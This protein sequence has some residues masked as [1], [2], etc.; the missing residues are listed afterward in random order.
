M[1]RW[2]KALLL[3]AAVLWALVV[4]RPYLF[5]TDE[6]SRGFIGDDLS[7]LVLG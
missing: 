7:V 4:Y 5:G 6:A 1:P 2:L 3:L